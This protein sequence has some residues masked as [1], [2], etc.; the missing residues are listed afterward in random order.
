MSLKYAVDR[1]A[2][3]GW[4]P[5]AGSDI[6]SLPD[7]RQYPSVLN[8][9]SEFG[10]AGLVLSIKHNLMFSCY[11]ATWCPLG[12]PL[13]PDALADHNHGTVVA[14]CEREAAVYALAQLR[15]AQAEQLL[16]VG[17]EPSDGAF[18]TV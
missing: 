9:Q 14:A 1:L 18:T 6:E 17:Q 15:T 5:S 8:V 13:D 12:E 10:R 4:H 11:R 2:E 16:A 3:S 7:G